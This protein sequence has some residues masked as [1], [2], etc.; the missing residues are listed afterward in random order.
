MRRRLLT[1]LIF[2]LAGAV[3]N[4]AVAWGCGAWLETAHAEQSFLASSPASPRWKMTVGKRT[5]ATRVALVKDDEPYRP[6]A[7]WPVGNPPYWSRGRHAPDD[8]SSKYRMSDPIA[9]WLIEEARGWPIRSMIWWT[10]IQV[11]YSSGNVLN[12][13]HRR[14]LHMPG[15]ESNPGYGRALPLRPIWPGFAVNTIFYAAILWLLVLGPF[16]LRRYLRRRR[17]LC[18]ACGYDLKHAEHESCPECGAGLAAGVFS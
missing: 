6:G 13:D 8:S 14:A 4:V 11:D 5:G 3:V 18:P 16:V 12:I 2:L 9:W 7:H 10:D 17:G 1:I 15:L